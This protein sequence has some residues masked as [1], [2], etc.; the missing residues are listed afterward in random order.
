VVGNYFGERALLK[1]EPRAA[2]AFTE[3]GC[4]LLKLDS[5]AFS[6][7]LGPLQDLMKARVDGYS[8]TPLPQ[9]EQ[10]SVL[11][12]SLQLADLVEVG[13]LGRGSMGHVKLVE[14]APTGRTF[15]LKVV[16]KQDVVDANQEEQ[17]LREKKVMSTLD[18]NFVVRL[19]NTFN[20]ADC[21]YFLMESVLGGELFGLLNR[22][23]YFEESVAQFYAGCVVCALEYLHSKNILYRDLK[24]ENLLLDSRG[25]L[26]LADFGFAKKTDNGM[27]WTVCGTPEYLRQRSCAA[28]ATTR[29]QT[30]GHWVSSSL[31]WWRATL[32]F[33]QKNC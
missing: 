7:L 21:V 12:P 31:R 8:D 28:A 6:L 15:A 13:S 10:E 2:T 30:G 32:L 20:G 26:K 4:T 17:I 24:P 11:D 22:F 25:Y 5:N 33:T 3:T 23:Q 18:S 29:A 16:S 19:F 1:Q 27:T 9:D 14:H